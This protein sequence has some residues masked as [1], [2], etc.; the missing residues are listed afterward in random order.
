MAYELKSLAA[1]L[2][3]CPTAQ[4]GNSD[5]VQKMQKLKESLDKCSEELTASKEVLST[6]EM[7]IN[8]ATDIEYVMIAQWIFENRNPKELT[9]K[10]Y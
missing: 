4:L 8:D 1:D 5:I 6:L 7:F 2:I 10:K 3:Q 9:G